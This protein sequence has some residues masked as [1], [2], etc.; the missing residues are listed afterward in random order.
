[1]PTVLALMRPSVFVSPRL[2]TPT[3]S[4]ENTTG[5]IIILMRLMKIV[6]IG[7]IHQLMKPMYSSPTASPTTTARM[8]AIKMRTERF[9]VSTPFHKI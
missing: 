1:M 5:T 4:D 9:K 8:S 7:A 3:I 6:P 2:V